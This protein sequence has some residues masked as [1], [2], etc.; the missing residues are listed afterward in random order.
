MQLRQLSQGAPWIITP[1]IDRKIVELMDAEWVTDLYSEPPDVQSD[2][3]ERQAIENT[4]LADGF[5]P[6]VKPDD[7]HLTHLQICDAFVSS[8]G[9]QM[10]QPPIPPAG[11][12]I[13]M[14]HMMNHVQAAKSDPMY[15]KQHAA[16]IQPFIAKIQSTMKGIQAQQQASAAMTNLRGGGPPPGMPPGPPGA[17]VATGGLPGAGAPPVPTAPPNLPQPGMPSGGAPMPGPNG[18]GGGLPS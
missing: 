18:T 5:M 16:D 12:G 13:F 17:G 1:E 4:L 3:Q 15:W 6:K 7:D 9:Q 8:R 14:Q 2:Q 11:L 10:G